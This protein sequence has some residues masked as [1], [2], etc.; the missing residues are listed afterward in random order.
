VDGAADGDRDVRINALRTLGT[1]REERAAALLMRILDEDE[2]YV[3]LAA[4]ESLQRLGTG[5][6][7]AAPGCWADRAR[8][9]GAGV[10]AADGAR[11]PRAVDPAS[12][13]A[14]PGCWGAPEWRLRAAAARVYAR[15][16]EDAIPRALELGDADGRV[17]AAAW[18][19]R[20]QTLGDSVGRARLLILAGDRPPDPVVRANA[21]AAMARTGE[22]GFLPVVW[23]PTS[24][25]RPTP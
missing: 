24:G 4:M 11:R 3:T 21:L 12:A 17:A 2:P 16:A 14:P 1:Y 5:A 20:S 15:G 10:P 7:T 9:G 23:T 22:A 8:P 13:G 6:A 18:T 25:R 19:R